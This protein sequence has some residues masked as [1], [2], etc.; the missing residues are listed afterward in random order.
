[1]NTDRQHVLRQSLQDSFGGPSNIR[2]DVPFD[3]YPSWSRRSF[4]GHPR[5][6]RSKEEQGGAA[7]SSVH[8]IWRLQ[9]GGE[10]VDQVVYGICF[11][12]VEKGGNMERL[13]GKVIELVALDTHWESSAFTDVEELADTERYECERCK[14][15][16]RSTKKFTIKKLPDVNIVNPCKTL[17]VTYG[18]NDGHGATPYSHE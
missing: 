5:E 7:C 8:D 15:K 11:V 16:Q 9:L 13:G 14:V 10:G 2:T 18:W 6:V 3:H 1:M 4:A 17:C 12:I